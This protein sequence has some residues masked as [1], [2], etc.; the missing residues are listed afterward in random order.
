MSKASHSATPSSFEAAIAELESIVREMDSGQLSL[1]HSLA[2]YERGSAL[3]KY[4]QDTLG[5][6]ERKLQILENGQLR[7]LPETTTAHD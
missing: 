2:A 1:D 5:A 7:D 4:C 3:L 6:A